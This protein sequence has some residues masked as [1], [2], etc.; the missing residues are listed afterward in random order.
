MA[1]IK[2]RKGKYCVIYHYNDA[3][4]VR[5]Q[6]WETYK[7]KSEAAKRRKEV[8]YKKK[9]G[10]F[11]VPQCKNIKELLDEYVQLYGKETWA[12][13][14][15]EGNVSLMKNYIIPM[16]GDT[17]LAD[18]NTRFLEKY[19]QILLKTPAVVNASV[20]RAMNEFVTPG[21]VRDIHKLLRNCFE[22]AIKWELMDK[23]PCLRASLP[24]SKP[25]K[26]EIWTADTLMQA[27]EV[28]DD[29][30][31]KL[32]LNLSFAGSL[33]IGELLGLTW[34]CIDISDE[35]ITSNRA[36]LFVN[37]ELQRVKRESIHQLDGKDVILVFPS[38]YKNTSTV[39]IL[40]T[41]KTES[42]I[43]KVFL[44]RSVA[45]MLREWKEKQDELKNILGE[46]YHDYGI[47]LATSMGL[48]YGQSYV[49]ASLKR[50]IKE[51]NLPPIVFHSLRHTSVTYKLKLNGGDIKAVQ[52][53][54]GHSQVNMVTDVYSHIIDEDRRKN[55]ELFEEAFYNR[56]N[57]NPDIRES[58]DGKKENVMK[59]PEG[60]DPQVLAKVLENPEMMQ[61]L[62]SLVKGMG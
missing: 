19:Y 34:N 54:S 7:T 37:K 15:Y 33:R 49:R 24:K 38:E 30:F 43:R 17:K 51:H 3:D 58:V 46:E 35:A 31:L 20:G 1:S 28:C 44:P 25:Q 47:V 12:L 52:G 59:I 16:I 61:L 18:I 21:T 13:S 5:R 48:P 14:T 55:A 36:Y 27:L 2:E 56:K 40:K 11:V 9:A 45:Y 57:L 53:D 32:C 41:P 6:K 8:E 26:R 22:Q 50:L 10:F 23:N 29:E 42:S 4:G 60:V 62:A 39:R